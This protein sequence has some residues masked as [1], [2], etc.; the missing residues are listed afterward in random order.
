[1]ISSWNLRHLFRL[2]S[3]AWLFTCVGKFFFLSSFSHYLSS[4]LCNLWLMFLIVY[5]FCFVAQ[6]KLSLS[7]EC[8]QLNTRIIRWVFY[9]NDY[10]YIKCR[11]S[12]V[13]SSLCIYAFFYLFYRRA[14]MRA[15]VRSYVYKHTHDINLY[16][17]C[18]K[19]DMQTINIFHIL[20]IFVS[21]SLFF[22]SFSLSVCVF[23]FLLSFFLLFLLRMIVIISYFVVVVVLISFISSCKCVGY[24]WL[25]ALVQCVYAIAVWYC[26]SCIMNCY[27]LWCIDRLYFIV[28]HRNDDE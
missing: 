17:T 20:Y 15:Y 26:F 11:V 9:W 18:D 3:F 4:F 22:L 27:Y 14:C 5:M 1:M 6:S 8:L 19:S 21:S 24:I 28:W 7:R 16:N 10:Y 13:E 2:S 25:S 23:C 12:A